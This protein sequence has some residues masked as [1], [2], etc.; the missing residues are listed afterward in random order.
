MSASKI[1][2]MLKILHPRIMEQQMDTD[3]DEDRNTYSR[4]PYLLGTH[5]MPGTA[6]R[7]KP[8]IYYI[9]SHTYIFIINFNL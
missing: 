2:S 8:Y 3:T 4:P 1:H 9:F 7:I 5:L 6:N